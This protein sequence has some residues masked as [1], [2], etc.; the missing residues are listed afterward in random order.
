MSVSKLGDV[1]GRGMA[2][3]VDELRGRIQ[4]GEVLSLALVVEVMGERRPM[5]VIRGRFQTDPYSALAALTR[6]KHVLQLRLD[7]LDFAESR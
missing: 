5:T 6:A 7:G 2:D 4:E 1:L 3:V